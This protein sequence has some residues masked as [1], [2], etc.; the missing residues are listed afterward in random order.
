MRKPGLILISG[1][2]FVLV[3]GLDANSCT[4]FLIS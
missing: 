1:M 2:L 4:Y 3:F